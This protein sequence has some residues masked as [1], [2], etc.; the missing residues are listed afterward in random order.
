MKRSASVLFLVFFTGTLIACVPVITS[1]VPTLTPMLSP[2]WTITYKPVATSTLTL[3]PTLSPLPSSTASFGFRRVSVKEFIPNLSFG[4]PIS[5]DTPISFEIPKDFVLCPDSLETY[6][7][8]SQKCEGSFRPQNTNYFQTKIA[9]NVTYESQ[10]DRF[11]N[12]PND[13]NDKDIMSF[14]E[15]LGV[16]LNRIERKNI[17]EFPI[18]ILELELPYEEEH[19]VVK[20]QL[21][22]R[23]YIATLVDTNVLWVDYYFHSPTD[24]EKESSIWDHFE[25]SFERNP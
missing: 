20:T 7:W 12:V 5:L 17:G 9:P 1:N 14:L 13:F 25:S 10:I 16:K 21:V 24:F 8:S 19:G 15:S 2:A 4:V 6:F 3:T 18:L 22:H 23:V 11:I